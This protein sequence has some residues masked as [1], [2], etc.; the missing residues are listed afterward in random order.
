MKVEAEFCTR[1]LFHGPSLVGTATTALSPPMVQ[2]RID[3]LTHI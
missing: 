2:A 1:E 3:I